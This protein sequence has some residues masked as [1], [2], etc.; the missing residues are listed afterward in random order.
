[1]V[2]SAFAGPEAAPRPP[3]AEVG[4][5]DQLRADRGWLPALSLVAIEPGDAGESED[6]VVGHVVCT[7]GAVDGAPGLGLGPLAVRPDRQEQGVG[8]ALMHAVLGA[9]EALGEP[10]VALLGEPAYYRRF[11]FRPSALYGVEPPDA[12][13]GDYFQMRLL[14]V[15]RPLRGT[16]SYAEPFGR[17]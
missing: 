16:F 14:T 3:P 12:R 10:Y 4:L 17:L 7:R 5:L 8:A 11:G 1:M 9:A 13:W 15:H 6:T 2:S